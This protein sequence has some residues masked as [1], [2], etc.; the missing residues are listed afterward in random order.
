MKAPADR[1][2]ALSLFRE[3]P[4]LLEQAIADLPETYLDAVPAKGGWTI[5]QIVHHIVDGDDIWKI[6]IKMALGNEN[7]ELSLTWY[8][9]FPQ[10]TWGKRWAYSERSIDVS[11][12]FLEATRNHVLQLLESVP[13]AWTQSVAVRSKTDTELEKVPIG[14]IIQMQANHVVHHIKRIR[15]IIREL[16]N[17]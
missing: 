1:E 14:F 13:D 6:G 15:E 4:V 17:A 2:Q 11:L 3:G 5:R 9:A 7:A 12:A 8:S 10:E 16:E